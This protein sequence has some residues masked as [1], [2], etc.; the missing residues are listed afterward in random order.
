MAGY[1]TALNALVCSSQGVSILYFLA[2][3]STFKRYRLSHCSVHSRLFITVCKYIMF[4]RAHLYI[5]TMKGYLT[6]LYTLFCSSQFVSI[7]HF[8]AHISLFKRYRVSN[9][10][11]HS[12]LFITECKQCKYIIFP[13]MHLSIQAIQVI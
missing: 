1:L 12:R 9:C 10:F 6:A 7:V 4:P 8:L 13:R 3:I 2:C 11:E 5:Q